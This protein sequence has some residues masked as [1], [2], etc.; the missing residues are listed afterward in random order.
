MSQIRSLWKFCSMVLCVKNHFRCKVFTGIISNF[1]VTNYYLN[2][3]YWSSLTVLIFSIFAYL[4]LIWWKIFLCYYS[5]LQ[6]PAQIAVQEEWI[7]WNKKS[8]PSGTRRYDLS[9]Y[10]SPTWED[11]LST[12]FTPQ[13]APQTWE[14][15]LQGTVV[16]SDNRW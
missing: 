11:I 8:F 4:F 5:C 9:L 3:S 16:Y 7:G 2:L 14:T 12:Y 6:I 15:L 13:C 10:F 1:I